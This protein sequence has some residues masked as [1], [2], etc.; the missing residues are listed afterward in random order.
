[1]LV[2]LEKTEKG[3]VIPI[4][5]DLAQKSKFGPDSFVNITLDNDRFIV[6]DPADPHYTIEELL[7]GMTEEHLHA[8]VITSPPIGSPRRRSKYTTAELVAKITDENLPEK[9]DF[10]PPVGR[11]LL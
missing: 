11:E 3:L 10:G 9:I 5:E 4:P 7:E 1:M 8:E 2:Q 6:A